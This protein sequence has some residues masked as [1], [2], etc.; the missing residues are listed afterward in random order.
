[1]LLGT[2]PLEA[3]SYYLIRSISS[4]SHTTNHLSVAG[5]EFRVA[6]FLLLLFQ[7]VKN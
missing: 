3:L 4:T 6:V 2:S 1:M 5:S 7:L